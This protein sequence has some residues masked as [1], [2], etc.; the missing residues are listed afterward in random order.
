M[1]TLLEQAEELERRAAAGRVAYLSTELDSAAPG[2]L[3]DVGCGNGYAVDAWRRLGHRAFGVDLSFYRL[4]RWA[5]I[6]RDRRPFVVADAGA[7]PFRTGEFD[8]V[9][10]SGMIEHVGVDESTSPYTVRAQP[11]QAAQ[12]AVVIA[13]LSRVTAADGACVIDCPN[14]SFPI[15]FWHG[16]RLGALRF[17]P[18][19]DPL[20]PTFA[21]LAGWA[22]AAGRRATLCRLRDRLQFHQIAARWWGRL[23]TPA[24]KV[25]LATL[26][27]LIRVGLVT[28][29]SR[30]VPYLVV[31]LR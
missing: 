17:H 25:Y 23:L 21:D 28:L 27:A 6:E 16:D 15:D 10:S 1:G 30:L 5:A 26:D 19:P 9:L 4:S 12:R 29:P 8:A 18:F 13:D 11:D 7:L 3:V 2:S 20:L 31:R 14:G 22:R 24:G